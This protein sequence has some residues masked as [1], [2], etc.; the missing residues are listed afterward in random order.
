MVQTEYFGLGS[1]RN[2][3][4]ILEKEKSRN[5]F[6]VTGRNSYSA[7]GA[8]E[9]IETIFGECEV[10]FTRFYD[11]FSNPK[12]EDINKGFAMFE[13][14]NYDAIVSIGGGS[15]IDVAKSIKLFHFKGTGKKIPL[16][17]IPTTSG[18][19]SEATSF[20]VYYIGKEKQSEGNPETTLPNYVILDPEL[21]MSLPKEIAAASGMDALSQ[22][23]ESYWSINSSKESKEFARQGIKLVMGNLEQAVNNPSKKSK[24]N[25]MRAANLAG[26]A[27]N[28]T[29][30]TACHSVAYPITSYF[31]IPHGHAVG[32]TLGEMLVYNAGV[33]ETDCLDSRGQ[34][35]V[36]KSINGLS[37]MIGGLN[38]AQTREKINKLMESVGLKTKLSKL[39][40]SG[41]NVDLIIE[42]GFNPERVKNNPRL[43]TK[44]NLKGI[45]NNIY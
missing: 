4:V 20:I 45:L 9:K 17:A 28:I 37:G 10:G 16:V 35:Y 44:Q 1:L 15:V 42:K 27:I 13:N 3:K 7:C 19:G 29:K 26:K 32:L 12:L 21:T 6:L 33:D 11:F 23:V 38:P 43:L 25:M 39:G 18:S 30:T 2:L 14:G 40:L 24:E 5:V 8:K 22:A 34:E 41:D 36:K 31:Q